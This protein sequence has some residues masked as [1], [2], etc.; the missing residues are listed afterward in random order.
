METHDPLSKP[1]FF[2]E[3]E[4]SLASIVSSIENG[5]KKEN[6]G[7]RTKSPFGSFA[8]GARCETK[9][10][11][12]KAVGTCRKGKEKRNAKPKL[13]KKKKKKKETKKKKKKIEEN[14]DPIEENRSKAD[15]PLRCRSIGEASC[16]IECRG[17]KCVIEK[18]GGLL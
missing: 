18:K 9:K 15:L 2:L 8:N 11:Q 13:E 6:I 4:K 3:S 10:L 17:P 1:T 16:E 12:S 7:R 5:K 14:E